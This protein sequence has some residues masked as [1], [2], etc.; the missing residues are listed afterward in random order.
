MI[1]LKQ[2]RTHWYL[3]DEGSC[4]FTGT[5]DV[6]VTRADVIHAIEHHF[7]LININHLEQQVRLWNDEHGYHFEFDCA[8]GVL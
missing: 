1:E 8:D 6:A 7:G 4:R 2:F 3:P 5:T